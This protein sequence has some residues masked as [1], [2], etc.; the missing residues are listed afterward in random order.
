MSPFALAKEG[1]V[2]TRR[3][4]LEEWIDELQCA[5][6]CIPDDVAQAVLRDGQESLYRVLYSVLCASGEIKDYLL[7]I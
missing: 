6:D 5:I 1:P 7:D 3:E 4:V 2:E